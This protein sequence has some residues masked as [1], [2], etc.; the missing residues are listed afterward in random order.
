MAWICPTHEHGASAATSARAG[1]G[2]LSVQD[3]NEIDTDS[4]GG[5]GPRDPLWQG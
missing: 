3:A 2:T 4:G 1:M 5:P